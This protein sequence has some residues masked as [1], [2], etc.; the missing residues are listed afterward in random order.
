MKSY[1]YS[2]NAVV[3]GFLKPGL[4]LEDFPF[5]FWLLDTR[6]DNNKEL[7]LKEFP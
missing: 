6:E 7:K 1:P 5:F 3:V 2:L 4:D